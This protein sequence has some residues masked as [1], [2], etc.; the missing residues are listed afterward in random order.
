M[1][2]LKEYEML[3]E[4][5]R[6]YWTVLALAGIAAA[7]FL[8]RGLSGRPSPVPG[9]RN[10]WRLRYE[11]GFRAGEHGG[12]IRAALPDSRGPSRIYEES[13]VRSGLPMQMVRDP[14]NADRVV[15]ITCPKGRTKGRFAAEFDIRTDVAVRPTTQAQQRLTARKRERYLLA[16]RQIQVGSPEAQAVVASLL[17]Q[18]EAD[19]TLLHHLY[20]YCRASIRPGPPAAGSRWPPDDAEGASDATAVLKRKSGTPTGKAR[21]LVAL[22]RTAEIPARIVTGFV[23]GDQKNVRPHV[24]AEAHNGNEWI[25]C[26][27]WNGRYQLWPNDYLPIRRDGTEIV[28]TAGIEKC[29]VSYAVS[30]ITRGPGRALA[31]TATLGDI[32]DLTRLP[33]A[34]RRTM[35]ILLLLPLGALVTAIFRNVIGLQSFGTFTPALLALSLLY[36]DFWTGLAVFVLVLL[37]GLATRAFLDRL[38]LLMVPRLGFLLTVVVLVLAFCVSV[39]DALGVTPS[40]QA[41]ILPLVIVTMM[42]ERFYVG[43]DEQG[44][45]HCLKRLAGTIVIAACCYALL[46]W[47][48]LGRIVVQTPECVLLV[49]ALL[50]MIGR[51]S[52]Y[53]LGEL[54]RFRDLA[55]GSPPPSAAAGSPQTP[56]KGA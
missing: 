4:Q 44:L 52:G 2:V 55:G 28:T 24:W 9:V 20:T 40:T 16:E 23:L 22:C 36:A 50:L 25:T 51:Y 38:K 42:I 48:V 29:Q 8:A 7:A 53:R 41:V 14:A 45:G 21:A 13:F 6:T 10:F 15:A 27:P 17:D 26:D 47:D 12:Q 18:P 32:L 33:L 49:A 5:R 46:Q 31:R 43:C 56:P 39:L 1:A 11:I 3:K 34:M 19:E 30:P 35:A 37:I 54:L